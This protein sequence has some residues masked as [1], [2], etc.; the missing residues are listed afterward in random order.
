MVYTGGDFTADWAKSHGLVNDVYE[1]HDELITAAE[2]LAATIASNSPL[3]TFGIKKVLA[4]GDRRT[5]QE[6]LDYVAQWNSSFLFS[7][8]LKEA[9]TAF[10]EGRDP[11]F[12]GT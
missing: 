6:A 5:V 8:D 4:A 11:D 2:G 7:N 9:L 10:M 12:T 3:V 1:S